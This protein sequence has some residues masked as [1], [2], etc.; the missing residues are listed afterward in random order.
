MKG[1]PMGGMMKQIQKM[2]DQVMKAQEEAG[3]LEVEA[4][5]GGGMVTVKANG[6]N[7][8]LE[9]KINPDAVDP[10]DIEMLEDLVIA[11][12]NEALHKAGEAAAE[13]M[14]KATGPLA[15]MLPPGMNLPGM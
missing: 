2:Q 11:A 8:V 10:D 1:G 7:E 5:A 3:N 9:L 4:T 15:S 12:V 13:H 6:K 14:S